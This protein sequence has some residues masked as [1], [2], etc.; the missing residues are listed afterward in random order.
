MPPDPLTEFGFL[1]AS[2]DTRGAGGRGR[3]ALDAA[4]M[5]LGIVE[6]DD[7]AAGVKALRGTSVRR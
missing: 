2:F 5:R 6:V 1:V 7:Q 3:K 4:Y